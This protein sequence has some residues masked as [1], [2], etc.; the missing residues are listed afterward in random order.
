MKKYFITLNAII[1][2]FAIN[3]LAQEPLKEEKAIGE[4]LRAKHENINIKKKEIENKL[5]ELEKA[6]IEIKEYET[7]L[8]V[9]EAK[10]KKIYISGKVL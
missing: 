5:I 9:L 2:L 6:S 3:G 4:M 10:D 7:K 1:V 8:A